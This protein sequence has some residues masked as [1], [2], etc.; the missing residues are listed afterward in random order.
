MRPCKIIIA[1]GGI[2]GLTLA[3]IF[4][5]LGIDYTLLEA[6][7][8][9]VSKA[10]AG[11]CMLPFGL[12]ILDQLG[13]Y[14]ELLKHGDPVETMGVRNSKGEALSSAGDMDSR[15]SKRLAF[16]VSYVQGATVTNHF[17]C[18]GTDILC[19]G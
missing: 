7:P 8:D 13:C 1:G 14:E 19:F 12:R 5:K 16:W 17:P 11:I 15:L 4:D 10:G 2:G 3:L 6:Y 18:I 9:I